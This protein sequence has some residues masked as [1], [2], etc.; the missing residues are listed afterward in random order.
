M[1][2]GVILIVIDFV[3]EK[4]CSCFFL[5]VYYICRFDKNL[6]ILVKDMKILE[7]KWDDVLRF[8]RSE[9]DRGL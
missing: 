1:M 6:E 4:L 2:G 8:V 3:V 7:V 9:E 5:E